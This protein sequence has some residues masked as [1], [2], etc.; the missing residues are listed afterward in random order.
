M[1][2]SFSL[3]VGSPAVGMTVYIALWAVEKL[4]WAWFVSVLVSVLV[5]WSMDMPATREVFATLRPPV[6]RRKAL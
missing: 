4:V 6:W 5:A 2:T 3:L 1:L